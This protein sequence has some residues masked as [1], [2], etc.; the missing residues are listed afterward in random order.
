VDGTS[1]WT[2]LWNGE[3]RMVETYKGNDR[4][5]FKYD[6]MGRRV[7]KCVYSG[8]ALLSK[9]CYV[10]DGF[11]CVEELDALSNNAIVMRHFWQSFDVGLDVILATADASGT[12]YFLHDANKNVMQKTTANG[13]LQVCYIYS[14]F[15]QNLVST[16]AHM[17]FS[18]EVYDSATL[19]IY[20]NY[21]YLS[22][23]HGRWLKRDP[24]EENDIINLYNCF[25]N[26]PVIEFDKK[27]LDVDG[28]ISS[29][30]RKK[31]PKGKIWTF[32]NISIIPKADGCSNPFKGY[33]LGNWGKGLTD[34][35]P[36]LSPY[37]GNPD[38]PFYGVSFAPACNY[39]DYCYSNCGKGQNEC[40]RG[41]QTRAEQAC[42]EAI[43]VNVF[44][45]GQE[46][47]E[48]LDNCKKWAE[49]YY[50]AISKFGK[51]SY[52]ARQ[53]AACDCLC[54]NEL[55][56]SGPTFIDENGQ[57]YMTPPPFE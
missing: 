21:R 41:L 14:P 45:T 33:I 5:T 30:T 27:G 29:L 54:P 19:L 51:N 49:A 38:M 23:K 36:G 22:Q 8:N 15:G 12:S 24:I 46:K 37:S 42:D 10:Y 44:A 4:L 35:I 11:K 13:T 25:H 32:K 50:I 1:G 7:E 53:K 9:T 47:K 20:Y 3:N 2:Q 16:N 48:W 40:D 28:I 55:T 18:S 43:Y 26:S 57:Y 31:C 39:H 17:G 56:Q 52:D 6:Y 34:L